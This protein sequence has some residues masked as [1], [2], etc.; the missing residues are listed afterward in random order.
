MKAICEGRSTSREVVH[1]SLDM[2]RDVFLRTTQ[3][4]DVLKT[5]SLAFSRL[6]TRRVLTVLSD[7][8]TVPYS[9]RWRTLSRHAAATARLF[10]V[11]RHPHKHPASWTLYSLLCL[12]WMDTGI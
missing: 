1:E 2:Y 12:Y 9:T 7:Y 4:I 11:L 5:A 8:S 10:V 3:R 6:L